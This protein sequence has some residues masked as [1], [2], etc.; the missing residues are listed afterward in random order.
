MRIG[1]GNDHAGY[2]LKL[3]IA[4][5]LRNSGHEVVDYGH[6]SAERAD[7]PVFGRIVAEAVAAGEVEGGVVIC[8]TGV[9]ISIAANKVKGI[10]CA[11]VSEPFSALLSRRHNNSNMVAFGARVVGEDL[12]K[13]IVDCWV[14]GEFEGGRHADRVGIITAYEESC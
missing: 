3:A 4:E 13:M 8:G 10:R 5:H 2:D 6:H 14:D 9:G 7:Y 11:C 12:A 1:I